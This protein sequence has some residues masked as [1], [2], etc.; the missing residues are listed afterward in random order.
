MKHFIQWDDSFSFFQKLSE[1][2]NT[3]NLVSIPV[4][5]ETFLGRVFSLKLS[6]A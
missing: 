5:I 6:F 1:Q 3:G 4:I 2:F